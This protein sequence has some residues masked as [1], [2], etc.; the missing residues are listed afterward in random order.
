MVE[1]ISVAPAT[2]SKARA[3][4]NIP[5]LVEKAAATEANPKAAAPIS[6]TLLIVRE[7]F[8]GPRRFTDLLAGLPGIS[9]NLL[10]ER[11]KNLEQQGIIC[12]RVL[13]RPAGST[14]YE[15]TP[16]GQA[17]EKTLLAL[18]KWGSQFVPPT[19]E[20]E[21]AALTRFLH[22]CGLPAPS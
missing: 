12:R 17:S 18:G 9:T 19:V 7:L 10:S 21:V 16:L 14:V 15:L 20:G 1:G 4:I 8:P 22:L 2:P 6:W 13:P 5:A 11:L 3:A